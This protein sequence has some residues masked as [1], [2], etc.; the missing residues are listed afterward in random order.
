MTTSADSALAAF[1]ARWGFD[2]AG[3]RLRLALTHKSAAA[4]PEASNE[5]MEFLGDAL[6]G[7]I[8][9]EY[10]LSALPR[11]PEGVLSRARTRL[12]RGETLADAARALGVDR[13][14]IVGATEERTRGRNRDSLLADAFEALV[15]ALYLD[16]GAEAVKKFVHENLAGPMTQ[17]KAT[18]PEPDPKTGLQIALQARGRGLPTYRIVEE[19]GP[20]HDK[21]FIAEALSGDEVLGRGAGI[22]KREAQ[23]QAAIVALQTLAATATAV[24]PSLT[25]E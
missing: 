17:V 13:L 12:V 18:P 8:V 14:L 1:A 3:G 25:A 6:L 15:G 2:P 16:A 10:L 11:V 5:R 24:P 4:S 19:S 20:D 7:A 23:A 9:A 22:S 21:R